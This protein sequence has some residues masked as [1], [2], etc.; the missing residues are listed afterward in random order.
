MELLTSLAC[1]CCPPTC[2]SLDL[3]S[4]CLC[5]RVQVGVAMG[6]A[7]PKVAAVADAVVSTNDE[8]GVAEAIRRFVLEPRS[9]AAAVADVAAAR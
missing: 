3:L 5:L 4:I 9:A 8:D 6:N 2:C 7:A 1:M